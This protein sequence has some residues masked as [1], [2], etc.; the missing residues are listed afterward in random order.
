MGWKG[1]GGGGEW[2]GGN[3]EVREGSSN[4]DDMNINPLM[5]TII[6]HMKSI[7]SYEKL[8]SKYCSLNTL[9]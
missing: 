9:V 8:N 3:S 1:E 2:G 5:K 7:I 4:E 6:L